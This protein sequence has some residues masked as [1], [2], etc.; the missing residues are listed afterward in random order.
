MHT[1]SIYIG[2]KVLCW[3][4]LTTVRPKYTIGH[5]PSGLG[6]TLIP[7]LEAPQ[8]GKGTNSSK[9]RRPRG[10]LLLWRLGLGL[11][12]KKLFMFKSGWKVDLKG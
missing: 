9:W 7:K 12:V 2:P 8:A 11:R 10:G 1:N 3:G 6:Y 4:L 5:G